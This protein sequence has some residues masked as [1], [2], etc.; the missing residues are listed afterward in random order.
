MRRFYKTLT[1]LKNK[2]PTDFPVLVYI[3]SPNK[4][5]GRYG[6]CYKTE[7]RYIIRIA[8][9]SWDLMKLILIHEYAHAA[10]DWTQCDDCWHNEEWGKIYSLCWRIYAGED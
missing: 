4:I 9:S 5:K 1:R 2:L 7:K 3:V 8:K 6:E 10:S